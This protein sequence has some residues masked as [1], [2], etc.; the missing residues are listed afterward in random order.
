MSRVKYQHYVP[1]FYLEAFAKSGKIW[2]YDK[3]LDKQYKQSA[4]RLGGETYFY[5]LSDF[6]NQP[7]VNQFVENWFTPLES[8]ASAIL[9]QWRKMLETEG[10]FELPDEQRHDIAVFLIVQYLR[11]PESRA[12][13]TD[14]AKMS[15]AVSF[16]NFLGEKDPD[17]AGKIDNP[18]NEFEFEVPDDMQVAIHIER[19]LDTDLIEE[20][21]TIIL[22]HIWVVSE[23]PTE[24]PLYTSDHPLVTHPHA[25]HPIL[26]LSGL[27]SLGIQ[28]SY[29]LTP[30]Y[31]L[32]L[33]ERKFWGSLSKL[34]GK[35]N[36]TVLIP[37]NIEFENSIQVA[38]STR[39]IYCQE[40]D[41]TLA[42]SMCD[43]D[44]LLRDH[45]RVRLASQRGDEIKIKEG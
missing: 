39:F 13:T 40:G 7:D 41:F 3:H 45:H 31:S 18:L 43:N 17:L 15:A 1:R 34:D 37:D 16:F 10:N 44:P 4:R 29:P 27:G 6:K 20:L 32:M 22:N 23:N 8:R 35:I 24:K 19:I 33:L 42:K 14:I 25:K 11:T 30:R 2:C 21:A 36:P 28:I 38:Q 9:R 26:K 5:E 12:I